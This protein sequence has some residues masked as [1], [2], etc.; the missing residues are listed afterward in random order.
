MTTR[1]VQ[2]KPFT[3]VTTF[4]NIQANETRFF[5]CVVPAMPILVSYHIIQRRQCAGSVV[6]AV[7]PAPLTV[8]PAAVRPSKPCE[9]PR[10]PDYEH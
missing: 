9:G 4:E 3:F 8:K 7:S 5:L 2:D 1:D 6:R 10:I